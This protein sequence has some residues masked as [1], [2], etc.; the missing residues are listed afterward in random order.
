MGL[1]EEFL[2]AP[3]LDNLTSVQA[4]LSAILSP[5]REEGVN[6]AAFFDHEE[7]GS[8][9]K[10]GAGSNLMNML[11]EKI[12]LSLGAGREQ[13]L[14]GME[15]SLLLS[16]DVGHGLH[17]NYVK[18]NDPTNNTRSS[19]RRHSGQGGRLPELR[20]GQRGHRHCA[21]AL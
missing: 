9:T 5:G 12:L 21:A 11:V 16:V 19:G 2:S 14:R 1:G 4:V 7:I 3:R 15:D 10:Q 8:R 6:L 20:H 13:F 18:K 17:P